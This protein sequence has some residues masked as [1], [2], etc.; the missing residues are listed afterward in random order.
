M[1]KMKINYVVNIVIYNYVNNVLHFAIYVNNEY[2]VEESVTKKINK[3]G[4]AMD[5]IRDIV[6]NAF[7]IKK[8]VKNVI[9]HYA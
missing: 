7:K 3:Y 6:I 2:V 9:N 8:N 5:V 4:N 1:K